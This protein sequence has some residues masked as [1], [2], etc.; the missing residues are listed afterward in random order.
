MSLACTPCSS[1]RCTVPAFE[2]SVLAGVVPV[3]TTGTPHAPL[4]TVR[5]LRCTAD[6][7]ANGVV[8]IAVAASLTLQGMQ[9]GVCVRGMFAD[10][11]VP[12]STSVQHAQTTVLATSNA[13]GTTHIMTSPRAVAPLPAGGDGAVVIVGAGIVLAADGTVATTGPA[14]AIA[15]PRGFAQVTVGNGQAILDEVYNDVLVC[16]GVNVS[17]CSGCAT[18][19]PSLIVCGAAEGVATIRRLD[20]ATKLPTRSLTISSD[21]APPASPLYV[22]GVTTTAVSMAP[23]NSTLL[24]VGVH[25]TTPSPP[26]TTSLLWVVDAAAG[27]LTQLSP[28]ALTGFNDPVTGCLRLGL[29]TLSVQVL[30]V[31]SSR[32]GPVSVATL[33]VMDTSVDAPPHATQVY[34]F[35]ADTMPDTAFGV[36]GIAT[37]FNPSYGTTRPNDAMLLSNGGVLVVGNCFEIE[38]APTVGTLQYDVPGLPYLD[39][40]MPVDVTPALP[41]PFLV[42]FHGYCA[43]N[44]VRVLLVGPLSCGCARLTWASTVLGCTTATPVS[45]LGDVDF[46]PGCPSVRA[47]LLAALLAV[48]N[49]A[50]PSGCG[51]PRPGGGSG[52]GRFGQQ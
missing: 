42:E 22:P 37:W 19:Q 45:L 24:V 49:E 44:V 36:S 33:S 4:H 29:A 18:P 5:I 23:T 20:M 40:F 7:P 30:R 21:T 34:R 47:G 17:C 1:P 13:D 41:V 9:C 32:Q 25:V 46:T 48:Q 35:N 12:S 16:E 52:S 31:M 14:V 3:V 51:K 39:V 27:G 11:V 10:G 2:A 6:G 8:A 15:Y 43:C 28:W 38:A 50:A 26:L